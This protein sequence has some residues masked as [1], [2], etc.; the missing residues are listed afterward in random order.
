MWRLAACLALA[1]AVRSLSLLQ[2]ISIALHA[3][4]EGLRERLM[5][6]LLATPSELI[7]AGCRCG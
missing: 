3:L 1:L 7:L 6:E 2:S 4:L 5:S